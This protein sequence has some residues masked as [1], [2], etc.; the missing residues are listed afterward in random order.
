MYYNSYNYFRKCASYAIS[1]LRNCGCKL[2]KAAFTGARRLKCPWEA[3]SLS[4][5][6]F[7]KKKYTHKDK[8][9]SHHSITKSFNS[10]WTWKV[11]LKS[12]TTTKRQTNRHTGRSIG[13]SKYSQSMENLSSTRESKRLEDNGS[14]GKSYLKHSYWLHDAEF[15]YSIPKL[16]FQMKLRKR[17]LIA[18]FASPWVACPHL[19]VGD[20]ALEP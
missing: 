8:H 19:T 13:N 20:Q 14:K 9:L 1:T 15:I 7:W 16:W 3:S 4:R 12:R 17:K 11:T 6:F 10:S 5:P 2:P 18:N